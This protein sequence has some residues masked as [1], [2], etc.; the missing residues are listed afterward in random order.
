[1]KIVLINPPYV[2]WL[3]D[4][5]VEPVGLLYIAAYVRELGHEVHLYDPY[6]GESR[7]TFVS[8]LHEV[9]PDVVACAVYTVSEGFCCDLAQ[10][11]KSIL[12]DCLFVAGG[13]HATFCS[14]RMLRRCSTIDVIAKREAEITVAEL[15]DWLAAG[16]AWKDLAT[17]RGIAF[18]ET[19]GDV[20][21]PLVETG[22]PK[23]FSAIDQI[24][25]PAK[26]LL[27]ERYYAIG[28][29]GTLPKG[30]R[31]TGIVS[32]RGCAYKCDFCVSPVF[33]E[34]VRKHS[35]VRVRDEIASMMEARQ[36]TH[37]HF[38]DD[39]FAYSL[40]RMQEVRDV[41]GPLAVTWDCY[42]R[43]DCITRD[44]LEV[45]REAGCVQARFGV[46]TGNAAL[47]TLRKGGKTAS[48]EKHQDVVRWCRELGIESLASYIIG[49][50]GESLEQIEETIDFADTIDADR[51][52]FYRLT[53][54]PGT[55]Y[56]D[57]I[58]DKDVDL[59]N[60][61]ILE[62]DISLNE[63]LSASDLNDLVRAAYDRYYKVRK[64]PVDDPDALR[65]MTSLPK[66]A[67]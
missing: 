37:V 62:N 41:I 48:K 23:T 22:E 38:Y 64:P 13:P 49:F 34:G 36:I 35:I 19:R 54:Y 25:P 24:P 59:E 51:V 42:I 47:R 56:W 8:L 65:F 11:T 31:S 50:P 17:V 21:A 32:A 55:I 40:K 39:V 52:G 1:M 27:S 44:M 15:L 63:T 28:T 29:T 16:G 12:P 3:N 2:G 60:H 6:I 33:F 67:Y 58:K 9:R 46:E 7:E 30:Y 26:D 45:M 10:L 20:V 66:L 57:L 53:P 14:E 5:K 61:V 18:L 43:I 4:I